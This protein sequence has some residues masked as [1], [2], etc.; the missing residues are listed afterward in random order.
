[1]FTK[2]WFSTCMMHPIGTM[3]VALAAAGLLLGGGV[4]MCRGRHLCGVSH[5]EIRC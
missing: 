4:M 3:L 2:K 5:K 1:M